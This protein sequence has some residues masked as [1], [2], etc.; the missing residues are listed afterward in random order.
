MLPFQALG[1]LLPLGMPSPQN[2][3]ATRDGAFLWRSH[4]IQW[5][6]ER[7]NNSEEDKEEEMAH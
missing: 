3:T 5:E 6:F 7:K 2:A 4:G 1:R